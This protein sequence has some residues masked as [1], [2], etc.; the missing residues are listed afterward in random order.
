D[1]AVG[2]A[3]LISGASPVT[4]REFY[5]AYEEM[6]GKQTIVYLDDERARV[7]RRR[8]NRSSSPFGKLRRELARRP[9][10]RD[11]L[12]G[13]PPLTWL[14]A[15][16]RRLPAPTQA[17]LQSRLQDLWRLETRVP[18]FLPDAGEGALFGAQLHVRIDKARA[19]LGY[20]PAFDLARG[21]AL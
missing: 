19:K 5:G 3:F 2:E 20:Q 9:A 13:L 14:I 21:M 8:Q 15:G 1:V 7:E 4:W 17:A 6:V 12:A 16:A 11:Y 18:L 10:V